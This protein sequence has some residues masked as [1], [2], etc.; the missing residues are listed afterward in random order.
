[1][2]FEQ[3]ISKHN[4]TKQDVEDDNLSRELFEDLYDLWVFDMP[5]GTAKARDG[6]PDQWIF[7]RLCEEFM[8]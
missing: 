8:V 1:M 5:Y 2:T 7:D 4:V 3:I 6:D